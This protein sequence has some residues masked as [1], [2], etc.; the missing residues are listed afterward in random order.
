MAEVRVSWAEFDTLPRQ[1]NVRWAEFD[2]V[3]ATKNVRV[4]WCEFDTLATPPEV[5]QA[6][7]GGWFPD[8]P[9]RNRRQERYEKRVA[10]GILPKKI[11][12]AAKKVVETIAK[13]EPEVY[14]RPDTADLVKLL[15]A[16]LKVSKELPDYS[17]AI[18]AQLEAKKRAEDDEDDEI[19]LL[20]SM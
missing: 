5:V 7:S 15:M 4:Y 2:T 9:Y 16:E 12:V 17:R 8:V 10:M 18:Q 19:A 14:Y 1:V 6:Y 3:P 20:F 13:K 11:T